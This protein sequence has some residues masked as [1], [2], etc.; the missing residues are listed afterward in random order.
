MGTFW[1]NGAREILLTKH[2]RK[3]PTAPIDIHKEI[4]TCRNPQNITKISK[5]YPVRVPKNQPPLESHKQ[6]PTAPGV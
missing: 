6:S 1:L 5:L 4:A 2:S 3:P